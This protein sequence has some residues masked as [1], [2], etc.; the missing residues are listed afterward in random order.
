MARLL[1]L[2]MLI[3][4][5]VSPAWAQTRPGES[6][7]F[8]TLK[9]AYDRQRGED[10]RARSESR[11]LLQNDRPAPLGDSRVNSA[12]VSERYTTQPVQGRK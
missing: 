12:P 11:S 9:D 5:L 4:V 8:E 1:A 2:G 6:L 3:A 7:P 10:A